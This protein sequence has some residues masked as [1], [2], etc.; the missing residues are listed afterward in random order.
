MFFVHIIFK[1]VCIFCYLLLPIES[2]SQQIEINKV[3]K[4]QQVL[5]N[6]NEVMNSRLLAKIDDKNLKKNIAVKNIEKKE[7]VKKK[8]V[9]KK[10]KKAS[11]NR[12]TKSQVRE[13]KVKNINMLDGKASWYGDYFHGRKTAS[14]ALYDKYMYTSAHRTLPLGTIVE[15]VS[16]ETKNRVVVCINDRGP[17]IRGRAIDVSQEVA[18]QLDLL[19]KGTAPVTLKIVGDKKGEVILKDEAFYVSLNGS[20]DEENFVGPF[21]QFADA[22][23]MWEAMHQIHSESSIIIDTVKVN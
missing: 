11:K 18:E 21:K 16:A 2:L 23:V 3:S 17:Y 20:M 5:S 19:I 4:E 14:G 12:M 7:T 8:T 22:S 13:E 9:A 6:F 1:M 15:I 10:K